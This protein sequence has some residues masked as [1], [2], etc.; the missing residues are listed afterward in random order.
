[1]KK[2]AAAAAAVTKTANEAESSSRAPHKQHNDNNSTLTPHRRRDGAAAEEAAVHALEARRRGAGVVL[3]LDRHDALRVLLVRAHLFLLCSVF[4]IGGW[5][6]GLAGGGAAGG[7]AGQGLVEERDAPPSP[8]LL[9]SWPHLQEARFDRHFVR[10]LHWSRHQLEEL[11]ER[12]FLAAQ[13]EQQQQQQRGLAGGSPSSPVLATGNGGSSEVQQQQQLYSFAD[14]F[15]AI[16]IEDFSS[17]IS[18]VSAGRLV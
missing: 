10:D 11:A 12:R 4:I 18:K 15:K 13:M 17:Y 8:L 5:A 9:L 16:K 6:G 7:A 2:A 1:M 3:E 14:L